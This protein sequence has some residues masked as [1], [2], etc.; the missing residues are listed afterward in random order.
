MAQRGE[1]PCPGPHTPGLT[2]SLLSGQ[3][4]RGKGG[5]ED[6]RSS[7]C[8]GLDSFQEASGK[9]GLVTGE[10]GFVGAHP[11]VLLSF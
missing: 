5:G 11:T 3:M 7:H 4:Q 9:Q 6:E 10:S 2:M 8:W 1:V